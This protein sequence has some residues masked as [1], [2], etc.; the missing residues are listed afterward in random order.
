ML[1]FVIGLMVSVLVLQL[2][3]TIIPGLEFETI[4]ATF[5]AAVVMSIVGWGTGM[6]YMTLGL[7]IPMWGFVIIEIVLNTVA[8]L[9]ASAIVSG[10]RLSG[11]GAA[12][13]AGVALT[14]VDH[15]IP[16]A[17]TL[18]MANR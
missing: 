12:I 17:M 14:V 4:G 5:A 6:V 13:I 11:F 1:S 7:P 10:M 2:V 3:A 8:L 15:A 18:I 16:A 9:F